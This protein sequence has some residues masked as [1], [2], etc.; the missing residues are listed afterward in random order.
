MKFKVYFNRR[1]QWL[2][3]YIKDVHPNTF[4]RWDGGR[5]AYF[6]PAWESPRSGKFGEIGMVSSRVRTDSI[7]HEMFH[8]LCEWMWAN[9]TAVTSGNEETLAAMLDE[10]VRNFERQ[11]KKESK[12]NK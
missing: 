3:V 5:W 10:L 12:N 9:R 6:V 11:Y 2:D 1:K 7:V 8:V 4:E